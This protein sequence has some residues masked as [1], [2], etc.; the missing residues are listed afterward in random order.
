[1]KEDGE[2]RMGGEKRRREERRESE[3]EEDGDAIIQVC[4]GRKKLEWCGCGCVGV[5]NLRKG[6]RG[7]EQTDFWTGGYFLHA[8]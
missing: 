8:V 5:V 2:R 6:R 7:R 3:R 4:E 1:M